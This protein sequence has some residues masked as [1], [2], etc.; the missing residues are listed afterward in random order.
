MAPSYF[1]VHS[2]SCIVLTTR[3]SV[4]SVFSHIFYLKNKKIDL[5]ETWSDR[6]RKRPS[7]CWFTPQMPA[8]AMATNREP[9][10]GLP[11][12]PGPE[13]LGHQQG[14]GA[15]QGSQDSNLCPYRMQASQMGLIRRATAPAPSA[16]SCPSWA[17][18][19]V[20]GWTSPVSVEAE[21]R[22]DIST[23]GPDPSQDAGSWPQ[24]PSCPSTNSHFLSARSVS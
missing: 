7:T 11:W 5:F 2:D 24:R 1:I 13:H 8:P 20:T 3:G 17:W 16:T 21:R 15:Q 6:V 22:G 14:A 19:A 23:P 18:L 12:V 10:L 9:P 4:L